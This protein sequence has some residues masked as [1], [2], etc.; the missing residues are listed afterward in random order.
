[1]LEK[2]K[3]QIPV[4]LKGMIGECLTMKTLLSQENLKN[5]IILYMGGTT[6]KE[7]IV[8]DGRM[9]QVKT[10][11]PHDVILKNVECFSSPTINRNTFDYVDYIILVIVEDKDLLTSEF[12]IFDKKEFED[13]SEV[14][15]WSGKSRGDKSIYCIQEIKGELTDS[16]KKIVEKYYTPKYREL[17]ADAKNNWKKIKCT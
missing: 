5:S 17:F 2:N 4:F 7:D 12:Y 10:H 6:P 13:F 9:L 14:G 11:F 1:L 15:C 3:L 8:V 16:A